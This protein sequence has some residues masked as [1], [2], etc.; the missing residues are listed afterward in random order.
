[1]HYGICIVGD[2]FAVLVKMGKVEACVS[3]E[4]LADLGR[5]FKSSSR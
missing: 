3:K 2:D 5:V 1:M 4:R